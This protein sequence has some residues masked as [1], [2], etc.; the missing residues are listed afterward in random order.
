MWNTVVSGPA[1]T[2]SHHR[3]LLSP[4]WRLRTRSSGV[5]SACR[6]A[7]GGVTRGD[8]RRQRLQQPVQ[9]PRTPRPASPQPPPGPGTPASRSIRLH[10]RA[11]RE[12]LH[13]QLR[14]RKLRGEPA[15]GDRLRRRRGGD[16]RR[17]P[18][19]GS[20]RRY[21]RAAVHHPDQPDPPVRLLADVLAEPA[22]TARPQRG[23]AR[24]ALRDIV[25]LL[26]GLQMLSASAGHAPPSQA[27]DP[28]ATA[29]PAG[30]ATTGAA[31]TGPLIPPAG[32]IFSLEVPN[33]IRLSVTTRCLSPSTC[34][35][36]A[37]TVPASVAFSAASRV[38]SASQNS[39]R[40]RQNAA[41]CE[42]DRVQTGAAITPRLD[43]H[44]SLCP[45]PPRRRVASARRDHRILT[46]SRPEGSLP[47]P[48]SV[49]WWH[50]R[51][52]G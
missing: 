17:R 5:S 27:A 38:A 40:E 16:H 51:K 52:A 24:S 11:E 13:Q 48:L 4:P 49:T 3:W 30:S 46:V 23:Q 44:R 36:W 19:S 29:S 9:P 21:L 47:T 12:L 8:R 25:D 32:R 42:T 26:L 14:A 2:H 35:R 18:G 43:H 28:A 33:S 37:S 31:I 1:N 20:V 10:R 45:A 50:P 6:C 39:A 41:S 15:P 22:H 7:G 34:C